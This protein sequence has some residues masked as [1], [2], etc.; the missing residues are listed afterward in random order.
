MYAV[1]GGDWDTSIV[2]GL[3][4]SSVLPVMLTLYSEIW[5]FGLVGLLQLIVNPFDEISVTLT[6]ETS[7]GTETKKN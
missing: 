1:F 5:P 2:L 7:P 6:L 4:L 3:S